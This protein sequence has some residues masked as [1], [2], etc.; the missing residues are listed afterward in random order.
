MDFPESVCVAIARNTRREYRA[1]PPE[2]RRRRASTSFLR[3]SLSW[4]A[5]H[6]IA[7][8]AP[9][10]GFCARFN[11]FSRHSS[12][13]FPAFQI[14]ILT[15]LSVCVNRKCVS[16]DREGFSSLFGRAFASC[17][18][19]CCLVGVW[20]KGTGGKAKVGAALTPIKQSST[21][22]SADSDCLT[23]LTRE[24]CPNPPAL[25]CVSMPE[26]FSTKCKS[27]Q[28]LFQLFVDW[29]PHVRYL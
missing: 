4:L 2:R 22:L 14:S 6:C 29:P 9:M 7:L 27:F 12:A 17:A 16:S 25:P 19:C 20:Q 23:R 18:F 15:L 13:A 10:V 1:F 5:L 3:L 8:H 28:K 26:T 24:Q 21:L 11:L